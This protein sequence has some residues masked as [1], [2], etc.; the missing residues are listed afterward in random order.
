MKVAIVGRSEPDALAMALARA[1]ARA[2]LPLVYLGAPSPLIR[3]LRL[4][5]L[6]RVGLDWAWLVP[7][8]LALSIRARRLR[9]DVII[10]VKTLGFRPALLRLLRRVTGARVWN[11]YP[12]I[13]YDPADAAFGVVE[14]LR[15]F[16]G[17]LIW[18]P[19]LVQRLLDDG[20]P[21][22][23]LLRFAVDAELYFAPEREME[24]DLDAAFVGTWHPD[25]EAVVRAIGPVS[26]GLL[27][28][29]GWT[30]ARR[31][32]EGW[33]VRDGRVAPQEAREIYWRSKVVLN[34]L[35]PLSQPG[36][37]M[38]TFEVL[39]CGAVMLATRTEDHAA[40][41]ADGREAVLYDTHAEAARNLTDLLD[42]PP[43][44]AAIR[45]AALARMA[46]ETYEARARELIERV[47]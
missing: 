4:K 14:W 38:R 17:V 31:L 33:T 41:F 23:E 22:V 20:V 15:A 42:D 8:V 47:G 13:P 25:R 37:N 44:R 7:H 27:A 39:G 2:G 30:S 26:A 29:P 34:V 21:R 11:L 9:P 35:H 10:C 43:R 40:L 18:S 32:P 6:R 1:A 3:Y 46:G 16:D 28:G 45:A 19:H 5:H 36:Y 12:D 24:Q